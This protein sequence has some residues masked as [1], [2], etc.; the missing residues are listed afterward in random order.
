M[1]PTRHTIEDCRWSVP[2]LRRKPMAD[3]DDA[4]EAYW[5][6]ERTRVPVA[7]TADAC[8]NCRHWAPERD[9]PPPRARRR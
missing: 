7:V 6:C 3:G 2:S 5:T 4:F 1:R 9:D 8:A